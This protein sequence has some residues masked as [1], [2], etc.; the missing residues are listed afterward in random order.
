MRFAKLHGAGNDFLVFDGGHNPALEEVLPALVPRLCHRRLGIGADGVLLLV[1]HGERALRLLYWNADGSL[2]AFCA[3]GTR[4]AARFAAER[5]GWRDMI[6]ETGFAAIPAQAEGGR[7]TLD[8]PPP[9]QVAPWRSLVADGQAVRVRHIVL[10]VPHLV[11]PVTWPDFWQRPL[12]PMATALRH[13]PEL[14]PEGANVNFA[15]VHGEE[16]AVRSFERGVE[17]E[18]LSCGSGDVASA[19]VAAADRW[20]TPPI[21]VRT[22][23]GRTLVV[24]PLGEPPTCPARLAGPAEW[25]AEGTVAPELL[26]LREAAG[27]DSADAGGGLP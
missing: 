8:L 16:L 17:G 7:V 18:T 11:V 5:W 22:A 6:I 14:G 25:V 13:H 20:L 23:S 4:C 3:N 27:G 1:P 2:A 15:V 19:L 10:G 9:S 21:R 24:E 26:R 12:A